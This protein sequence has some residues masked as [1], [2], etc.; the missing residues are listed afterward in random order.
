[1]TLGECVHTGDYDP[2]EQVKRPEP[3]RRP[4]EITNF[5]GYH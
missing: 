2:E 5:P 3:M 1:M 4:G